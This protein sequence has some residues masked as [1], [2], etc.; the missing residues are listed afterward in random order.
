MICYACNRNIPD[1]P[2]EPFY[3]CPDCKDESTDEELQEAIETYE[4][5]QQELAKLAAW[6]NWAKGVPA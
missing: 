2:P 1:A 5:L 3:I 4:R 6:N